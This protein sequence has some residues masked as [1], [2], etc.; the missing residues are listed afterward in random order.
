MKGIH[1]LLCLAAL[2]GSPAIHAAGS[3]AN[4]AIEGE[5]EIT[6]NGHYIGSY[7]LGR[8][9][10]SFEAT[11][12]GNTVTF[13]S[14]GSPYN[15]VAEF[16]DANTLQF[17]QRS[18][19]GGQ[20]AYTLWQSPYINT[21]GVSDLEELT[22]QTFTATFSPESNAISFPEGSGLRYGY[23]SSTGALSYW[24]DAFDFVSAKRSGKETVG[25]Y[26]MTIQQADEIGARV[27]EPVTIEIQVQ[28]DGD[29]YYIVEQKST[30]FHG[31][32]IPFTFDES[33]ST[34]IFSLT[35]EGELSEMPVW[36]APFTYRKPVLVTQNTF[37]VI[38]NPASGFVFPENSGIGWFISTSA[39][40]Y[41]YSE[42]YSAFYILPSPEDEDTT[43]VAVMEGERVEAEY[44][45]LQGVK[46]RNPGPGVYVVRR[47]DSVTK[48]TVR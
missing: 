37:E 46:V 21:D 9:T 44:Y 10:E 32:A 6:L 12:N 40:I 8:F 22:E 7:S 35:Y 23:F 24:D 34:A 15:I 18:V 11:L 27:Q 38:F 43:G 5:W 1:T 45:T 28:K 17:T 20:F 47:G 30:Y 16:V 29:A 13:K 39:T 48:E 25:T 36:M 42:F 26:G 4:P 3:V 2:A 33:S 14:S 31:Y 19:A 41:S